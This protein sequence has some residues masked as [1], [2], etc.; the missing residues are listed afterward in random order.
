VLE[1]SWQCPHCNQG[2]TVAAA[3]FV[4]DRRYG[5]VYLNFE[6]VHGL[7]LLE[8]SPCYNET[9]PS[10]IYAA[11]VDGRIS[12]K[13]A[14]KLMASEPSNLE[15]NLINGELLYLTPE[16]HQAC[17]CPTLGPSVACGT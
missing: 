7:A 8:V 6:K 15:Q 17:R 16:E 3:A 13:L 5:T 12:D 10:L 2:I 1:P 4:L 9:L 14:D 11:V